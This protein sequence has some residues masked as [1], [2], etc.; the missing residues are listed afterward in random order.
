MFKSSAINSKNITSN[1]NMFAFVQVTFK[2][3][4]RIMKLQFDSFFLIR[5]RILSVIIE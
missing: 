4:I 2:L 3:F 5:R 1:F